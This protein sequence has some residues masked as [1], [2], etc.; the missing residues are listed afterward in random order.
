VSP[1]VFALGATQ[2][3]ARE[4]ARHAG[5]A[6]APVEERAF[7]DG[8]HKTRPLVSVRERDVYV[9]HTLH[10]DGR[11]SANDKL[12][13]LLLFIATLKDASAA[14]VT[15]VMPYL[16]YAR[17]DRRTKARDP[18]AT[19]YVAQLFE[20]VGVDRVVALDVHNVTAY[21]N[22]FRCR[23]EHLEAAPVFVRALEAGLKDL[24]VAVVSPDSGGVKRADD[25]RRRLAARLARDVDLAFVEKHR[26]EGVVSGEAF[27]GDVAGKVALVVDDLIASGTT[28]AR[29]ASACLAA[30]A[31]KA[32]AIATHGVFA[33]AANDVLVPSAFDGIYVTDSVPLT[34][35][36]GP[37]LTARLVTVS[38]APLVGEAIARLHDGRS[39][40][41]LAD[42]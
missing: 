3:F 40:L 21:Q 35:V 16:A 28:M 14:R 25:F 30:G 34:D 18:V 29:A 22:A 1:L 27:A 5:L 23:A 42:A 2:P 36:C 11:Q 32:I 12:V 26:S 6:L 9:V 8:E 19:R 15:A 17:K 41:E 20:A 7:E 13:R 33:P 4:A 38:V 24:P 37:Q 10:G 39:L 31:A